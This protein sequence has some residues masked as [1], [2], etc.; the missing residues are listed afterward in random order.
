MPFDKK[1]QFNG[2]LFNVLSEGVK[3]FRY[4]STVRT[5]LGLPVENEGGLS[6][7]QNLPPVGFRYSNN[8]PVGDHFLRDSS[9]IQRQEKFWASSNNDISG[10]GDVDSIKEFDLP[11]KKV[12]ATSESFSRHEDPGKGVIV[13]E[14]SKQHVAHERRQRKGKALNTNFGNREDREHEAS[15]VD[16]AIP[17]K[18]TQKQFFPALKPSRNS[19]VNTPDENMPLMNPLNAQASA[20]KNADFIESTPPAHQQ[21]ESSSQLE[22]SRQ[23]NQQKTLRSTIKKQQWGETTFY[24]FGKNNDEAIHEKETSVTRFESEQNSTGFSA[25]IKHGLKTSMPLQEN[26]SRLASA[27][28]DQ[29]RQS[30]HTLVSKVT[31]PEEK[32]E[33]QNQQIVQPPV[34]TPSQERVIFRQ[35]TNRSRV[36][37][38][39]WERSY[40]GRLHLNILR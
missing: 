25:P 19:G 6:F 40:L 30:V 7:V 20:E 16:F 35:P 29:L 36:P 1:E 15:S 18:S 27:T 26:D 28:L 32:V 21:D 23:K 11:R 8:P 34:F 22:S 38:A 24:S 10:T 31:K 39:F 4:R 14:E 17:G 37:R 5:L 9:S 33:A 3:P 13:K 12:L 2:Y